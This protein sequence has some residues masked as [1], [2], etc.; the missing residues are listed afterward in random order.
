M[1]TL[2]ATRLSPEKFA[3]LQYKLATGSPTARRI[4]DTIKPGEWECAV[5]DSREFNDI[6]R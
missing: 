1:M 4:M 5:G 6:I 3:L 2:A